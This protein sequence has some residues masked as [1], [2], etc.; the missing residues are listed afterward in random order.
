MNTAQSIF[1]QLYKMSEKQG[2]I[3]AN[4]WMQGSMK[5]TVLLQTEQEKLVELRRQVQLL[6]AKHLG[7]G[8]SAVSAKILTETSDLFVEAEK[9]E[10]FI[11]TALELSRQAKKFATMEQ[12][13]YKAY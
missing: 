1:D 12:E 7:N 10:V 11:K 2:A 3:D 6:K 9:L 8:E 13:L 4:F 5:L